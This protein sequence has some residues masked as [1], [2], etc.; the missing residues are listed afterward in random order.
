MSN[1]ETASSEKNTATS[2][3]V[4]IVDDHP[5]M[6][7][8]LVFLLDSQP[9]IQVCNMA[10]SAREALDSMHRDLPDLVIADLT[11]PDKSGL[12]LVKDI[13]ALFEGVSVLVVSMHDESLYAERALRAGASGYIMKEAASENLLKAVRK[14]L[15]GGVYVSPNMAEHLIKAFSGS[16]ADR[17]KSDLGLLTDRELEVFELIGQAKSNKE[18][19]SQLSIS[20]KTV[21]AHKAKIRE[22][23]KLKDSNALFRYAVKWAESQ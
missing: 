12:E 7:D 14:V 11:L 17:S 1:T 6:R 15:E 19:A 5:V 4:L 16:Q 8:G 13:R 10:G 18:I 21:D 23:L 2:R 9:D 22:K 20:V 3:K